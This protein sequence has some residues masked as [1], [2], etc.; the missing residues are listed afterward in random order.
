MGHRIAV[1]NR[2]QLQQLGTPKELYQWPSNLFVAQFIG[3]PPMNLLPVLSVGSGQLQLGGRR[4]VLEG[5]MRA[6][7]EQW[8]SRGGADALTGGL[9]AE[10]LRL[11]PA[12]NRNLPAE[13]CHVE[14]LGNEQLLTCRLQE[15]DHLVQLR[16]DP[17]QRVTPGETVH[18]E[19]EASGWRLF[20]NG[21]DALPH[22]PM[23]TPPAPEP[24]LPP[25]G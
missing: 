18:L 20:D 8:Q 4:F 19:V 15:G 14:S 17:E 7:H 5:P 10:H 1:L 6:A 16:A 3:S 2:G 22:A 13:L 25:L 21:G 12:T 11:G 9:R 24:L 23:A